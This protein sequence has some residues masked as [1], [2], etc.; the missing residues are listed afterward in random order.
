[1]KLAVARTI[2]QLELK[3]IV[4]REQPNKSQTIIEKFEENSDV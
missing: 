2:E 4:L 1:M 3:P